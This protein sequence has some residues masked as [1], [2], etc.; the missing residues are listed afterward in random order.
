MDDTAGRARLSWGQRVLLAALGVLI[1]A[2]QFMIVQAYRNLGSTTRSFDTATEVTTDLHHVG[3]ETLNLAVTI[4]RLRLPDGLDEVELRRGLQDR[5][6]DATF[7]ASNDPRLRERLAQIRGQLAA[8]DADFARLRAHPTAAQLAH[9]RPGLQRRTDEI[10]ETVKSTYDQAEIQF[11]GAIAQTLHARTGFQRLLVGTSGLTLAVALVLALSL[12]R[13]ANRTHARAYAQVVA[14][15]NERKRLSEQLRHQAFH[16]PLTGLPNRALLRDR[17]E[18]ALARTS[19]HGGRLAVLLLDLDGFKTVNDTLGHAAGDQLLRLVAERLHDTVR[20]EDTVA[21]QGGDEFVVLAEDLNSTGEATILAER[22]LDAI[23]VPIPL[24]GR[25]LHVNASI[26]ITTTTATA[27]ATTTTASA[28]AAASAAAVTGATTAAATITDG[29]TGSAGV[30]ADELLRDADV[31]MY[32][33]KRHGPGR[34]RIFEPGMRAAVVDRAELEADLRHALDR[35]Q[36]HLLYQPIIHLASGR[37]VGA[38]ALLRWQHPTRG[39]L[40]PGSFIPLA[41]QTGLLIPIGMWVLDQACQQA[42]DWQTTIP[43]HERLGISVNLSAVQ[44][45]QPTFPDQVTRT[46]TDTGLDARH[47]TLELTEGLLIADVRATAATLADLH[48]RG[49]QIA[50]DDFGTGYSSLAYLGR[51]PVS[52]LKIDKAFV[53]KVTLDRE[54]A[55]LT[56]AIVK[57]ATTLGLA[58]IAEGIEQAAQLERLREFGCQYGQGFLFARPLDAARFA[59][60]LDQQHQPTSMTTPT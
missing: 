24:A 32:L 40:A 56:E 5:Q 20:A 23:T 1:V 60:L 48:A 41:E 12:R 49:V 58:S 44:L 52:V 18:R 8:F 54:A 9:D 21:R 50:I 39:L 17:L 13:R 7:G 37:I 57:L 15:V 35:D 26:G 53:D 47:L 19:R 14:E 4:D 30:Q 10:Q 45:A 11:I 43:G 55:A 6:L 59:A 38:E 3:E 33:A 27:T 2:V 22:L 42:R 25:S 16:D 28:A 51:L 46:L 29:A 31:A 36:L 34:Y